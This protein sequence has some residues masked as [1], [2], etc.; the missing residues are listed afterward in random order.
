MS[1]RRPARNQTAII[2]W[3]VDDLDAEYQRLQP[4]VSEWEQEPLRAAGVELS[5]RRV[6]DNNR[7]AFHGTWLNEIGG[8]DLG[9]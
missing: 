8:G 1:T 6:V 7:G 5:G 9:A 3:V 4:V 2:E